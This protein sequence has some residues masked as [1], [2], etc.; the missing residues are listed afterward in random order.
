[1]EYG[2]AVGDRPNQPNIIAHE[3]NGWCGELQRIAVAAQRTA[4]VP[5]VGAS[6]VGEDH[7]WREFYERGWHQNDNWWTD[8]GGTVDTPDVYAYGWKKNMSAIYAWK[9]DSSIY[10]V[11]SRYIHPE[12]RIT[13]RF[14]VRDSFLKPVD[15]ARIVVVVEG[16]K[17]ITWLK[18]KIWEKIEE[19]WDKLPDFIK[20]K[21]LQAIY[22]KIQERIEEIPD[23]VDGLTITTWNYTDLNGECTFELGKNR[24]YLFIIQ[25][26]NLRKPWQLAKNN[27]I[28]LLRNHEDKTFNVFFPDLSHRVQ[29]HKNNEMPE[30]DCTFDISFNTTAYQLQTNVRNDNI[31]TY[32]FN[33]KIDF[34]ILD[35]ENFENYK[36]G[37]GFNCYNYIE[38]EKSDISIN[39]PQGNWYIVFRNHARRTNIILDF[40]IQ[41]KVTTDQDKIQIVTPNTD[42]FENPIFNVGDTVNISG[43]ATEDVLLDING[44]TVSVSTLDHRWFYEWDTSGETPGEYLTTA[45][46]GDAQDELLI[47][48]IDVIPPIIE[49]EEPENGAIVEGE[50][51]EI[52]GCS[53]DNTGVERIEVAVDDSEFIEASGTETWFIE[54]NISELELDDHT[55]SARALDTFGGES[56]HSIYFVVNESGHVW[57]PE[58]NDIYHTPENATN[59]SNVV[60]YANVTDSSPF[61]IK[62]VVLFCDNG[63][64]ITEYVMYRYADNPVQGRHE[65]DP[66]KNES[67]E[68]I[69]GVELGQ[70]STG[71]IITYWIIAYDTANNSRIS[72]IQSFNVN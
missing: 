35:E 63:T 47:E 41:V 43:I 6:N 13:A 38:E 54:W 22:L 37:E 59:V 40:S 42:I 45:Y 49:I 50:F 68:P 10:D 17:D 11:T 32:E 61:A 27:A 71:E 3:H 33:G 65:E 26:G 36:N 21:I 8:S 69:F 24:E 4:L 23:S 28:R 20:G 2:K 58:I 18:N 16:P 53:S 51:I 52:A 15:G 30:G 48:L 39:T 5:S 9:G 56:V 67:N 34:F 70:F 31:G 46:C 57:S 12:D 55:I 19:I 72:D 66:L 25:Q 44:E 14:V 1:V 7:V 60:I 64:I 62:R 29:P